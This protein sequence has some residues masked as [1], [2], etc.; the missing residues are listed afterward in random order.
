MCRKEVAGEEDEMVALSVRCPLLFFAFFE[1]VILECSRQI[2]KILAGADLLDPLSNGVKCLPLSPHLLE[3]VVRPKSQEQKGPRRCPG[4]GMRSI[5]VAFN[6]IKAK[7]S[8]EVVLAYPDYSKIFEIYTKA[9]SKQ[10]GA[11]TT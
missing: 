7:I 5:K 9:S 3:S 10:L 1:T 4:S 8:R 2:K 11:A 6:H